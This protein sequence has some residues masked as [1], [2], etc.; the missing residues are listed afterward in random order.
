V[1]STFLPPLLRDASSGCQR[2]GAN[3]SPKSE[4]FCK[5]CSEGLEG[6]GISEGDARETVDQARTAFGQ[7]DGHLV[8]GQNKV[9]FQSFD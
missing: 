2:V 4:E 5:R 8:L 7:G 3:P 1:I 6:G 9:R